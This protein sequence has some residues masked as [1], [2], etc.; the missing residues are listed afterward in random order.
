MSWRL[1][2]IDYPNA[3]DSLVIDYGRFHRLDA[4]RKGRTRRMRALLVRY[5]RYPAGLATLAQKA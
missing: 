2:V 4:V 5:V 1:R 3:A